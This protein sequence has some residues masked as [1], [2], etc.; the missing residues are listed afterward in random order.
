MRAIRRESDSGATAVVDE[1]AAEELARVVEGR[2]SAVELDWGQRAA[3]GERKGSKEG[4]RVE[5]GE[6]HLVE[7]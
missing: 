1:M 4:E 2:D 5:V 7:Q 6:E 3:E